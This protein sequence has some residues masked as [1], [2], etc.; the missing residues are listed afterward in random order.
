V[1]DR[2]S[3]NRPCESSLPEDL[4]PEEFGAHLSNPAAGHEICLCGRVGGVDVVLRP[5]L[6]LGEMEFA[7]LTL[8]TIPE[9]ELGG[10]HAVVSS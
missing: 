9:G 7:F 5:L 1:P 10:K 4:A 8:L 3:F 2:F 6:R